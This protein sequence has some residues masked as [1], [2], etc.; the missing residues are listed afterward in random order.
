MRELYFSGQVGKLWQTSKYEY[1]NS[2]T[3]IKMK[4]K[5]SRKIEETLGVKQGNI[6]SSDDYKI[7]INPALVMFDAAQLGVCIGDIN[8]SVTGVA[9]DLYLMSNS[10]SKLQ[11][12][13]D[14][15][16]KYG[17]E[18]R[19]TYGANKT[20]ITVFGSNVDMQ[21]YRDVSPW[22]IGNQRINVTENNEHLGQIVSGIDQISKNIDQSLKKGRSSIF[23]L[24]GPA[25]AYKCLLGPLVKIHLFRTFTCPR[26]RSGL[27]S[28]ALR[29]NQISPLSIFHR[30]TLKGFLHLSQSTATPAV[31][32]LFGE[33][34]MEG[35]IHRDMYS[36]F[37]SVW[38]NPQ[39]KVYEIVKHILK[40]S[41][42]N[43]TTW[44]INLRHIS[45]MYALEDPLAWLQRDPMPKSQ[46]KEL[47]HTKILAFHEKELRLVASRNSKM[48]YLNVSCSGL[49]G[50]HHPLLI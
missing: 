40:N 35:K 18:Y 45:R 14:I 11:A 41:P 39:S 27:S 9:D 5:L 16:E 20:K 42:E 49:R 36:L 30:K 44:A 3:Q 19:I 25:F 37:Y 28:F 50:K 7:Y 32:F 1:E 22:K 6:N 8:V 31:H 17:Q 24:L 26:L 21:Y 43:S 38:C 4:G 12:L 23:G 10:Q 33:L 46:F 2:Y 29:K 47:V 48:K 13:I 34:P 15:A